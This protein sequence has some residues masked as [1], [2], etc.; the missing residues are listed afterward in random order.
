V[1]ACAG[2]VAVA[3]AGAAKRIASVRLVDHD[4]VTVFGSRFAPRERVTV[5]MVVFGAE[6]YSKVVVSSATG[7]FTVRFPGRALAQCKSYALSAVGSKGSRAL[8][9]DFIAGPCGA[10][11]SDAGPAK[12]PGGPPPG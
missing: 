5:R 7:R 3:P 8:S 2:A 4:P 9:R 10:D 1:L 11:P 6:R 12:N